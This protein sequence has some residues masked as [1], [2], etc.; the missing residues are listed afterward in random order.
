[1]TP[2]F[3]RQL[4][5]D[6]LHVMD[7]YEHPVIQG[8]ARFVLAALANPATAVPEG[9]ALVKKPELLGIGVPQR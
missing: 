3:A 8:L 2:E 1:V 9:Y 7:V 4:Q 6:A 5:Q